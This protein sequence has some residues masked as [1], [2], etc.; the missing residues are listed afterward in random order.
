MASCVL[1]GPV[2]TGAAAEAARAERDLTARF[3]HSNRISHL[4]RQA[5]PATQ[6]DLL[7]AVHLGCRLGELARIRERHANLVARAAQA[8]CADERHR[9]LLARLP[10]RPGEHVVAVGDSVT[11]DSLSWF[12]QLSWVLTNID[13]RGVATTNL[14][15]A[16]H[17][18]HDTIEM[19]DIIAAARPDHILAMLGTNDVRRHGPCLDVAMCSPAET[20]RNL[21]AIM[22]SLGRAGRSRIT[23]I[24]PIPLDPE[25]FAAA[26]PHP[27]D[28]RQA[29]LAR[30]AATMTGIDPVAIDT[31][32]ATLHDDACRLDLYDGVHPTIGGHSD[33]LSVIV[34]QLAT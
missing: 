12:E 29:D 30:V 21:R 19:L 9:D 13:T 22:Q 2:L 31:Y 25:K 14:A 23:L 4:R 33:L 32:R 34:E 8:W 17:S 1:T 27:V 3:T 6:T 10:F 11:A 16:G 26:G 28:W 5:T 15:V 18:T 7:D 24:T 20:D